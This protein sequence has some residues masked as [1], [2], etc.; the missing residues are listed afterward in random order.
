MHKHIHA[1]RNFSLEGDEELLSQDD[2][3]HTATI[4]LA[5][6][7]CSKLRFAVISVLTVVAGVL[8]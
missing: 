4:I 8:A 1:A 5:V 3:P 6:L 2:L 7:V